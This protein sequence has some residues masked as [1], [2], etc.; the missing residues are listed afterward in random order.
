M[1]RL[2][3]IIVFGILYPIHLYAQKD[4]V[5][6]S[7]PG[8]FYDEPFK[9]SLHCGLGN[10][11]RYTTNG[12]VPSSN[13]TL[14][15]DSLELSPTLFSK[16]DIYKIVNCIP[17]TFYLPDDIQR[18][19]VIRAAVFNDNEDCIS[20]VATNSYFIRSLG[21]DFHGLPVVSIAADSLSLFGYETG[22]FIPGINYDP[23][24]STHTGN[25][26]Q[27][28]REWE[29]QINMEFYEPDNRGVN[30]QCG[31]RTHG[32]ASR[33]FQQKGLRFYAREEYGKKRFKHQFFES[34]PIASFKR[35]N[36]HPFRCSNWLQTGGQ[37]YLSQTVANDL[38]FESLA[39]R[40]TVVFINGEYWG[41]YTLEESPDERY[42]E[43]HYDIDLDKV[44]ILKYWGVT[45]YGDGT[46]WW[47]FY[48]W[49]K[50]ADLSQPA[51]SVHAYTR[52]DV[53]SFIDYILLETFSANLDWPQNNVLLWQPETGTPFRW[54]F[55][56][57]DGC[58]TRPHFNAIENALN[59]GGN[60]VVLKHFLENHHFRKAFF[61][62]YTQLLGTYF[63][64]SHLRSIMCHYQQLV[65]DEIPAQSNRFHFPV[66]LERWYEDMEKANDF[67]TTRPTYFKNEIQTYISTEEIAISTFSCTPNPSSGSFFINFHSNVNSIMPLE[68]YDMTGRKVVGK[69]IYFTEGNN[70]I[71]LQTNL[72]SGLYLIRINNLTKRIVIL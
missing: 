54:I 64:A 19:I 2:L 63:H 4:A 49:L 70:S 24:D 15:S 33:W 58:F 5:T 30:Q 43:D 11:I 61:E 65:E 27:R 36:L 14:Y 45:Q 34:T 3:L 13:S 35:L 39:V 20:P 66:S 41:I 42:L 23:A 22:I 9:L 26:C 28:G 31:L 67:I 8:G 18:A 52:I 68:I 48:T 53:N 56:D 47:S 16:S 7:T 32:G 71:P 69:D 25:Y 38:D 60:S 57:G 10:H 40:Q 21:C 1:R 6:F 12:D 62:R 29:R 51:D 17:S 55:Y 37:E 44:N 59:Q 50:T 72:S 46:S